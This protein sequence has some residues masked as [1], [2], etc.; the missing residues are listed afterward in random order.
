[1]AAVIRI[2][3]MKARQPVNP[4]LAYVLCAVFALLM[5]LNLALALTGK[6][7]WQYLIAALWFTS[8]LGWLWTAERRRRFSQS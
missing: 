1:M 5:I 4:K 7:W 2:V 8:A 6:A 3:H